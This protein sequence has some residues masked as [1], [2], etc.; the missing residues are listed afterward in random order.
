MGKLVLVNFELARADLH[1]GIERGLCSHGADHVAEAVVEAGVDFGGIRQEDISYDHW[2]DTYTLELSPPELTGCQVSYI[3]QYDQSRSF[4]G[5]DWGELKILAGIQ[6][7]PTFVERALERGILDK[8]E[9]Q[10]D[11]VLGSFV[12]ALTGSRAA[13]TFAERQGE[14]ELPP[15]CAPEALE[16]WRFDE[17]SRTWSHSG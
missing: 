6:A 16:E 13:I 5:T 14:P 10:A 3:D 1:V 9:L 8:A 11:I 4:C 17:E 12:H 2:S 7:M 15:S